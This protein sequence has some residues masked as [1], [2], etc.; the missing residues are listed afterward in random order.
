MAVLPGFLVQ[1]GI[2]Y[3][4]D[5][6]LKKFARHTIPDDPHLPELRQ[7]SIIFVEAFFFAVFSFLTVAQYF[8]TCIEMRLEG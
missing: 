7:V 6:E 8:V 5:E 2:S 3:T 4:T 1:F